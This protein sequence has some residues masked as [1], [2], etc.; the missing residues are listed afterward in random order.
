MNYLRCAGVGD[1][2]YALSKANDIEKLLNII[3]SKE[4]KA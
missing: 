4:E 3:D 1:T 2:R